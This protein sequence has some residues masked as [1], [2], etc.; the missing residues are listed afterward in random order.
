MRGRF[1]S[2]P[3]EPTVLGTVFKLRNLFLRWV[4][5]FEILFW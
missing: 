4:S 3:I 5:P 2:M 1:I